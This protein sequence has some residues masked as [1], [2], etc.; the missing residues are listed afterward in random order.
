MAIQKTNNAENK[1]KEFAL[2]KKNYILLAIGFAIVILG[3]VL[4]AEAPSADDSVF[5]EEIYGFRCITL[6][7]MV[8]LAGFVFEIYAIMKK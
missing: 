3:F 8:V 7:P 4:M 5:K 6:A 2:K 1:E